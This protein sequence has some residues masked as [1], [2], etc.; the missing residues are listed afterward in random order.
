MSDKDNWPTSQNLGRRAFPY[1]Q[2]VSRVGI[3]RRFFGC[4]GDLHEHRKSTRHARVRRHHNGTLL[5]SWGSQNLV[6]S[7]VTLCNSVV[8]STPASTRRAGKRS[9]SPREIKS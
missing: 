2:L 1:A 9:P 3:G 5:P 6:Q 8:L 4:Q 7:C